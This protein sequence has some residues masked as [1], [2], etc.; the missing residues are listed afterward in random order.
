MDVNAG[1]PKGAK[2]MA[3]TVGRLRKKDEFYK[4]FLLSH[5][6]IRGGAGGSVSNAEIAYAM[7]LLK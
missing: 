3:V 7:R 2:G 4:M 6:T 5:N 1:E